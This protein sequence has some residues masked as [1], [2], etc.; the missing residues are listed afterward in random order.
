MSLRTER[1]PNG[2]MSGTVTRFTAPV[3]PGSA[4][5]EEVPVVASVSKL[6]KDTLQLS[7][8]PAVGV[9]VTPVGIVI[10]S[11]VTVKLVEE[12]SSKTMKWLGGFGAA[13]T[14]WVTI[15]ATTATARDT[16]K[17]L[18]DGLVFMGLE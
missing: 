18:C 3:D 7:G 16:I 12:F 9:T 2:P 10:P 14:D 8:M 6:S 13:F 17:G 15:V 5:V 4:Q 1:V 11:K